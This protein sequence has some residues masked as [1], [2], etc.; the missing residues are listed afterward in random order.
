[1]CA[2]P[3]SRGSARRGYPSQLPLQGHSPSPGYA[4][5]FPVLAQQPLIDATEWHCGLSVPLTYLEPRPFVKPTADV[6]CGVE[7]TRGSSLGLQMTPVMAA[8]TELERWQC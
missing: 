6:L 2:E 5:F 7:E 4:F 1:M 8:W 3:G